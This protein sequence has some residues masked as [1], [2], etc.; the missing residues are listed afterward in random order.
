[1]QPDHPAISV[2]VAESDATLVEEK[3]GAVLQ[4]K[5]KNSLPCVCFFW[6]LAFQPR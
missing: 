4:V 1:M 2:T 3:D 6:Q 5:V